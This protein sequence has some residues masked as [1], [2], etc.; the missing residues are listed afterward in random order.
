MTSNTGISTH[1]KTLK[2]L[3]IEDNPG[4]ARLIRESL[5]DGRE[6]GGSTFT[7]EHADRL[8]EGLERLAEGEIDAVLLDLSLPDSHGLETLTRMY[9]QAIGLP[10][11]VLT[12]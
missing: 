9:S 1:I 6:A 3:L 12:G 4:D 2:V 7:L 11:L 10:I 5:S 8:S